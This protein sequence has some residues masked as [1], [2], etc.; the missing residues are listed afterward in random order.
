MNVSV[1]GMSFSLL[2]QACSGSLLGSICLQGCLSIGVEVWKCLHVRNFH[3]LEVL[4]MNSPWF[5]SLMCEC[6]EYLFGKL[7][8]PN[9]NVPVSTNFSFPCR[10]CSLGK[11]VCFPCLVEVLHGCKQCSSVSVVKCCV[12]N[13]FAQRF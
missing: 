6:A 1:T 12:L 11:L 13:S 2:D 4:L 10:N 8:I 3:L 5:C 7:I 9:V